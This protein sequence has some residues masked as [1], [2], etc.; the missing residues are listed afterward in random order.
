MAGIRLPI[1]QPPLKKPVN[2]R[3]IDFCRGMP[4][5]RGQRYSLIAAEKVVDGDSVIERRPTLGQIGS[6]ARDQK[7]ARSHQ[8]VQFH[9]IVSTI[10]E[11]FV[12]A[13]S[14]LTFARNFPKG[15]GIWGI[16]NPA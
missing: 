10:D 1:I 9:Q 16:G 4:L 11:R 12:S 8:R 15:T 3:V 13:S 2:L 14:W 7:W 6:T 5:A